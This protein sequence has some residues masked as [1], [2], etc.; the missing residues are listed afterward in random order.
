MLSKHI[1]IADLTVEA[2]LKGNR[3]LFE[4]AIWQGGY[5]ENKSKTADMAAR[6]LEAQKEYNV[7]F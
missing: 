1:G 3:R 4:E 7:R 5:M 2:A 6:L